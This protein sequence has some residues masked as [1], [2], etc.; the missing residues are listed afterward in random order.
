MS[1]R[2]RRWPLSCFDTHLRRLCKLENAT[3]C[4]FQ[5]GNWHAVQ[6]LL[7]YDES[8]PESRPCV[9]QRKGRLIASY[10]GGFE[11]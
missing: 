2:A 8:Q 10:Y 3:Y 7:K 11:L 9:F 6:G 4:T 5:A 1:T